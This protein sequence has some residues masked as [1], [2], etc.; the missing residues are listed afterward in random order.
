MQNEKFQELVLSHLTRLTEDMFG[1]KQDVAE[2]KQDTT[3]LKQDVA[4]LKQDTA[5]LKQ[6]VAGLKSKLDLVYDHVVQITEVQTANSN[7]I[8]K[9]EKT[10]DSLSEICGKHEVQIRNIKNILI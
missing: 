2:L 10:T 7:R 3:T 6:D 8:L 1:L 9:L 4:G 5:T